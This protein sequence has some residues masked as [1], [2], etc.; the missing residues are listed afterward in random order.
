MGRETGPFILPGSGPAGVTPGSQ[1]PPAGRL[2]RPP[3]GAVAGDI[4]GCDRII[5]A[6]GTRSREERKRRGSKDR[7]RT[8]QLLHGGVDEI[9]GDSAPFSVRAYPG[10][11]R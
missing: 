6:P 8:E 5:D 9:A 3:V 7:G 10:G 11:A 1:P 4:I 2:L